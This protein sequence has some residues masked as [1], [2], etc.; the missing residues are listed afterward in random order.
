MQKV[1]PISFTKVDE[2]QVRA[3]A[4]FIA[5]VGIGYLATFSPLFIAI[6]VYD[7]A[8]RIFISANMSPIFWL[9]RM[10]VRA[11]HTPVHYVD[12]GP[13][14]FAAK[15]GLT[16]TVP[17]LYLALFGHG[18]LAA[19]LI[20]ILI[21]CAALEAVFNYCIGCEIYSWLHRHEIEIVSFHDDP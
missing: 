1:C 18:L 6:L 8:V 3:H 14:K 19:L 11:L 16:A 15:I 17:A 9:S 5:A 12:A 10:T 21:F 2:K 4:L 7:F 13:K 20:C